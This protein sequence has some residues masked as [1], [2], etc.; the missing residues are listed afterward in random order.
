MSKNTPVHY[1]RIE[2]ENYLPSGWTLPAEPFAG[3]WDPKAG[4]WSTTVLD[5]VD[6]DW[7]LTVK[8]SDAETLGRSNALKAAVDRVYRA[9]LGD[10]TRGLGRG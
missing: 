8:S 7:P 4:T 3:I 1:D 5:G 6:F 9:R 2:I 10:H